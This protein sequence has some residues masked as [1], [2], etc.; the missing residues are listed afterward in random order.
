MR[1][2]IVAVVLVLGAFPLKTQVGPATPASASSR[3]KFEVISIRPNKDAV[4]SSGTRH[5][6]NR[7]T[8]IAATSQPGQWRV[9]SMR[10]ASACA[11]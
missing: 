11:D 1:H 10:E 3:A 4:T 7:F 5:A 9:S 6:P 2:L 8:A